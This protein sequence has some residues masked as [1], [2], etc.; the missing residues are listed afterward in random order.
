[1]FVAIGEARCAAA[2]WTFKP[3]TAAA[4]AILYAA[5]GCTACAR[6]CTVAAATLRRM[7]IFCTRKIGGCTS[8]AG[9]EDG[10]G[11]QEIAGRL[12]GW[13]HTHG[14]RRESVQQVTVEILVCVCTND[15]VPFPFVV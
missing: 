1:M 15:R 13:T 7:S 12:L 8:P 14:A 2:T 9:E 11:T 4:A 3:G 5:A 6:A 10:E